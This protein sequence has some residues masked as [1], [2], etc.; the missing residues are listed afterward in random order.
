MVK[1]GID[2]LFALACFKGLFIAKTSNE[3]KLATVSSHY[4]EKWICSV[5]YVKDYQVILGISHESSLVIFDFLSNSELLKIS[6][7]SDNSWPFR[8]ISLSN[9]SCFNNIK[10]N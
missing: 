5:A 1:T 9:E 8:I 10:T 6:N 3:N 2:G 7:P 4:K